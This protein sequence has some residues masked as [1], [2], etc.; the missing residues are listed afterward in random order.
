[1]LR[2]FADSGDLLPDEDGAILLEKPN[3][4]GDLTRISW[5]DRQTCVTTMKCPVP[6]T[7]SWF[8]LSLEDMFRV[9]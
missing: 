4:V 3:E 5:L 7:T 8:T 1:L 9:L 6:T 2:R